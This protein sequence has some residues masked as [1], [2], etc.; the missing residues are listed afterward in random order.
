MQPLQNPNDDVHVPTI[1]STSVSDPDQFSLPSIT[2]CTITSIEVITVD[3]DTG[4]EAIELARVMQTSHATE[5][6]GQGFNDPI[7]Y[8]SV[9]RELKDTIFGKIYHALKLELVPAADAPVQ[10]VYRTRHHTIGKVVE[11]IG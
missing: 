8:Y 9:T 1:I 10:R 5:P 6:G 2:M 4:E 7:E 11:H 3:K